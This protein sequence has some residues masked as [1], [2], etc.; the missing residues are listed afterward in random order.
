[1]GVYISFA[2]GPNIIGMFIFGING[3]YSRAS[4][5]QEME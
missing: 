3:L 5:G 1:M 2:A 4:L